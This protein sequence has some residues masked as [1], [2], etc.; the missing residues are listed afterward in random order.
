MMSEGL[1]HAAIT[2]DDHGAILQI[3]A[4]FMMVTMILMVSLRLTIRFTATRLAGWDDTLTV[5]AMVSRT[6]RATYITLIC[7]AAPKHK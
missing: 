5:I 4:W 6:L 2:A 3:V 7:S 1:R